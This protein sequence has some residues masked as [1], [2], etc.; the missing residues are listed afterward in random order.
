MSGVFRAVFPRGESPNIRYL[1]QTKF[2]C[3][4]HDAFEG[5]QARGLLPLQGRG[6]DDLTRGP[7]YVHVPSR[8][9]VDAIK[10]EP[11]PV[12]M[13]REGGSSLSSTWDRVVRATTTTAGTVAVVHCR[14]IDGCR[15]YNICR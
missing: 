2:I 6:H 3:Q 9:S 14:S 8:F 13:T 11:P 7:D 10:A 1:C 15:G 12:E 4:S 5:T